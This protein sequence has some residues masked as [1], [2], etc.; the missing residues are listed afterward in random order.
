MIAVWH[1]HHNVLI[2]WLESMEARLADIRDNKPEH[3]LPTRERLMKP[4][5][6]S[7]PD[8]LRI[9]WEAYSIAREAVRSTGQTY[10]SM[11]EADETARQAY[12]AIYAKHLPEIE[13]LHAAECPDCPW[14]GTSIFPAKEAR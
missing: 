2:S 10:G 5:A 7:L 6:G 14:D 13:V 3:E 4:V 12:D 1:G 9:A 11:W 8:E